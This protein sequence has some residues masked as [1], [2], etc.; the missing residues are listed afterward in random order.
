M[1][2]LDYLDHHEVVLAL[3]RADTGLLDT[4]EV[5]G[6]RSRVPDDRVF[7]NLDDAVDAFHAA[8]TTA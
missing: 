5:Y 8:S 1:G 4:L 2:L 7:A 6:L 3:A